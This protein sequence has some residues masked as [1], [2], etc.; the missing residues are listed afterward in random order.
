MGIPIQENDQETR[1]YF[2][3]CVDRFLEGHQKV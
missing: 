2:E 3:Y 1:E